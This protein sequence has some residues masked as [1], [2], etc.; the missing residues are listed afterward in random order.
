M[1]KINYDEVPGC[2]LHCIKA[3]CKMADHCLRQLAMQNLPSNLTAVT[4]LNPQLTQTGEGCEYYRDDKPQV[5]GKGF[6]NMQKKM[7]PDEY[8]TFMYRLQGKFGRNPYFERRKGAQLCS[9]SDIK[10]VEDALKAIGHEELKF[11]A[12]VEKLNWND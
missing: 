5:Y 12:Y 6:K 9:P 11:D 10:Q 3:D 2:Y 1:S 7:F 8:Q 4:I